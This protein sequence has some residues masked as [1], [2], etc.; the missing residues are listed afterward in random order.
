MRKLNTLLL[1]FGTICILT[2]CSDNLSDFGSKKIEA[3]I[4]KQNLIIH[5]KFY[6]PVYIFPVESELAKSIN[7][8]VVSIKENEIKPGNQRQIPLSDLTNY[9]T[10]KSILVYYWS[11]KDPEPDEI[12]N[13]FIEAY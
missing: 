4:D 6:K 5:N 11:V 13:L 9:E 2:S 8:A 12:K 7:W 1:I 10:G 3:T